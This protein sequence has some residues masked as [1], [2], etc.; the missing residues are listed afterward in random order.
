MLKYKMVTYTIDTDQ[1][2]QYVAEYPVLTGVSGTGSTDLDAINDLK[3]NAK[4]HIKTLKELGLIVPDENTDYL[5]IENYSG[6]IS[7]RPGKYLHKKLSE[8]AELFKISINSLISNAV[9]AYIGNNDLQLIE[10]VKEEIN[11]VKNMIQKNHIEI[12]ASYITKKSEHKL[13]TTETKFPTD[14]YAA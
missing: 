8:T 7:Y 5:D 14:S 1:G 3:V 12:K 9:S 2:I 4:E 11:H 13:Y 6:K 10:E